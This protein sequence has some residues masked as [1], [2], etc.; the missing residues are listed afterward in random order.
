MGFLSLLNSP[1]DVSPVCVVYSLVDFLEP[2]WI[3]GPFKQT[4]LTCV[5]GS[6][7]AGIG[8]PRRLCRGPSGSG[9]VHAFRPEVLRSG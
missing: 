3:D 6:L 5:P 8:W 2:S 4:A 9:R 7:F 1:D